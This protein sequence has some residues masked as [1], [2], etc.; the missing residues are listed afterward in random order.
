MV[1]RTFGDLGDKSLQPEYLVNCLVTAI[2]GLVRKLGPNEFDQGSRKGELRNVLKAH[3][4]TG[5]EAERRFARLAFTLYDVYRKPFTTLP[6]SNA[7]GMRLGSS[8]RGY[9]A[10]TR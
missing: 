9:A 1:E 8:T 2:E 10:C 6:P 7:P 3:F 5:S 4:A